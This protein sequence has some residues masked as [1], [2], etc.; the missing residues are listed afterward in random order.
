M[1]VSVDTSVTYKVKEKVDNYQD[2]AKEK[3]GM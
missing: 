1:T 3:R 2:L